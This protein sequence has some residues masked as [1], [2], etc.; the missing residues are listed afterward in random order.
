MRHGIFADASARNAPARAP[1]HATGK[2][3]AKDGSVKTEA[4]TGK[5]PLRAKE[6]NDRVGKGRGT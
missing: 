1:C 4:G 3:N 5:C 6:A 2:K